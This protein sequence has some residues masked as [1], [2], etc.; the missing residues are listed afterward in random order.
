M[1]FDGPV[2]RRVVQFAPED[3]DPTKLSLGKDEAFG[4]HI[5]RPSVGPKFLAA[6][7][8]PV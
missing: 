4:T 1:T 5:S 3:E 6:L 8:R 7:G 2:Q